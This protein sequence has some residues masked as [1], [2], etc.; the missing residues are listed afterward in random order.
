M[1]GCFK[2]HDCPRPTPSKSVTEGSNQGSHQKPG[3]KA[4]LCDGVLFDSNPMQTNNKP[5]SVKVEQ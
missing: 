1:T 5:T 3:H 4:V 2:S